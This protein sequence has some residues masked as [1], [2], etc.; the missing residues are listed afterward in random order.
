MQLVRVSILSA[1]TALTAVVSQGG[2]VEQY[3]KLPLLFEPNRGQANPQA[4]FVARTQKFEVHIVRGGAVFSTLSGR[5]DMRMAGGNALSEPE[6]IGP[7]PSH[8]NYLIGNDP[9]RWLQNVPNIAKVRLP[10][11]LPGVDL[12]FYGQGGQ[13]EY[14][15]D[16]APRTDIRRLAFQFIGARELA[17][18]RD[19]NLIIHSTAGEFTQHKPVAWQGQQ[20][21]SA[22]Y[23][24]ID[25]QTAG[26]SLGKYDHGKA[27]KIDPVLS[28]STYLSGSGYDTPTGIAVDQLGSAYITG[29]TNS[30]DFP[31]VQGSAY[32]GTNARTIFVSKLNP[33]GTGLIYSTYVGGRNFDEARAI[34]VDTS[35][36]AYVTGLT[37]S[38][39]FPVVPAGSFTFSGSVYGIAFKLD[40]TGAL[41]Y[42]AALTEYNYTDSGKGIAV[43]AAGNA[44]VVGGTVDFNIPT[45]PG[46]FQ[47]TPPAQAT[48]AAFL[49]KLGPSGKVVYGTYLTGG[50]GSSSANAV[51]VDGSGN[52]FVT[53]VTAQADFPT[54]PNA[55][56]TSL[57]SLAA[58]NAFIT[59]VNPTGSAL[60][61]STLLG[62]TYND[63]PSAIAVDSTGNAYVTGLTLSTDF[64]TTAGSYLS[65]DSH[66]IYGAGFV[67]KIN[68]TGTGLVY[69]TYLAG[70]GLLNTGYVKPAA[71]ALA[72]VAAV[73]AGTT[74]ATDFPT[75]PGALNGTVGPNGDGFITE[76]NSAGTG[77]TYSTLYFSTNTDSIASIASDAMG[78]V[79]VAGQTSGMGF[80]ATMGAFQTSPHVSVNPSTKFSGFVSK[81][82]LTNV[83]ACNVVL[84]INAGSVPPEGGTGSFSFTL[85]DSCPW[86]IA[87]FFNNPNT[88]VSILSPTHGFGSSTVNYLVGYNFAT[89]ANPTEITVVGGA[90]TPGSN[91]YTLT[92]QASSCANPLFVPNRIVLDPLGG[93][94]GSVVDLPDGCAWNLGN[95][96]AWL[97][98][99]TPPANQTG[100][101]FLLLFASIN[102]TALRQGTI[103]IAGKTITLTQG[104]STAPPTVTYDLGSGTQDAVVYYAA[105]PGYEYSL[106]SNGDGTF[107]A[108]S[109]ASINVGSTAFDIVLQADFNGDSKSDILFYSSTT[110]TLKIGIGDG[111]G[112]FSYASTNISPGYEIQRGDFNGDGK[113]DLLFYRQ[114]DGSAYLALSNGDGT[115]NFI[116]QTFS[117]GFTTVAV[118]DYNGDGFSDVI[119]YNNQTAPYNAYLLLGDGTGHFTGSSLFFGPGYAVYPADLNAD[120][121]SDFILYRPSDGTVF[122]AI[123]NAT[124]FTYHYLLYSPGFTT[125]KIG[126]VNGDGFPDLVLYNAMNANGYLLLGDGA[127]NLPTGYSLFFGPG[128]D[129]V[130]LR[131]FNGDGKQD[132]I[133]YR[134]SDG[135]SFTGI[136]NGS[137]FAYT[138]N[139]FGPG[140]IVAR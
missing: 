74:T 72:G 11:A 129:F 22:R 57:R 6:A 125:F 46:A 124:S 96:P 101:G 29:T 55:F 90:T 83:I 50:S 134:S 65:S 104:P 127:G 51:T 136:S 40:S 119:V 133:L 14:D 38:G 100:S 28:Y 31:V 15:L 37:G 88:Q 13:L 3:G 23:V 25:R 73:V 91:V 107:T 8:T 43:D 2:V 36:N 85:A 118:A 95:S 42:T 123:S 97:K 52:A 39:D 117:P 76:L 20:N 68:P 66:A 131:D 44:Y 63:N 108:V 67:T 32:L 113:T 16:V 21:V 7:S 45:T 4:R 116:G 121:K 93:P 77:L 94:A 137:G 87:G 9:S 120:G 92:Q 114:S 1:L 19:G 18:D 33:S 81:I 26:I 60:V 115:F 140:R 112:H 64:P 53:G 111:A 61:Y 35:G 56:Q 62:G 138:Y 99:T 122:V 34:A 47:T 10:A 27:L 84:S 110:G 70:Q 82:D 30:P 69:S 126:D 71:V 139:Y 86:Q 109:T 102:N 17:L 49:V 12:D 98:I 54:T 128:M 48:G 75:T 79:Y 78:S 89:F 105:A 106:L 24:L 41:A 59:K 5:I 80:P 135:T 132:V 103:T 130:D 58:V